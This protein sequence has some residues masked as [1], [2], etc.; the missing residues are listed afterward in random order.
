[1]LHFLETHLLASNPAR[2]VYP[3]KLK[4]VTE[5]TLTFQTK[6]DVILLTDVRETG[7]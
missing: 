4:P 3:D 2:T 6:D 7:S 1:M 5:R